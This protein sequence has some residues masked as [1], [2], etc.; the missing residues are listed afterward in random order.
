MTATTS[1]TS[2]PNGTSNI[3]RRIFANIIDVVEEFVKENRGGMSKQPNRSVP[4]LFSSK[5]F[6]NKFLLR[7][8]E[9]KTTGKK[10]I[11]RVLGLTYAPCMDT[12]TSCNTLELN[13]EY[14]FIF[15]AFQVSYR[16]LG[17]TVSMYCCQRF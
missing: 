10:V 11:T 12:Y 7:R 17:E 8:R 16:A 2:S 15:N 13:V 5:T 6:C 9:M 1:V 4:S 3:L 14:P